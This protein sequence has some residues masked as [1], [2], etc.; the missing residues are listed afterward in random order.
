M[1]PAID[2]HDVVM[3]FGCA[4]TQGFEPDVGSRTSHRFMY[5]EAIRADGPDSEGEENNPCGGVVNWEKENS[6]AL[7]RLYKPVDVF[8]W[9]DLVKGRDWH[10]DVSEEDF[11]RGVPDTDE[12]AF[13]PPMMVLNPSWMEKTT[14]NAGLSLE[15]I[16]SQGMMGVLLA[17]SACSKVDIYGFGTE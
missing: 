11:W 8:W 2:E 4:P 12:S 10:R 13:H 7:I 17:L 9:T 1:G 5:P 3:R 16:P 15:S 6:T 14:T